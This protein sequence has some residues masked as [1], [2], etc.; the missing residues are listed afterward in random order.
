MWLQQQ[1]SAD[2]CSLTGSNKI[3]SQTPA[4]KCLCWLHGK[5]FKKNPK[6]MV[7]AQESL[8]LSLSPSF[9]KPALATR[10]AGVQVCDFVWRYS[11]FHTDGSSGV[12]WVFGSAH[13]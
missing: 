11:V 5:T 13:C 1:K 12:W 8:P 2:D 7:G 10:A 6:E 3:K 4:Q 9:P